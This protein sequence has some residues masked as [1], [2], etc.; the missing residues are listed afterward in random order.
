MKTKFIAGGV[1]L[2]AALAMSTQAAIIDNGTW[3]GTPTT[4][5]VSLD[6][7]GIPALPASI[8]VQGGPNWSVVLFASST[9]P[10]DSFNFAGTHVIAPHPGDGEVGGSVVGLVQSM[11]RPYNTAFGGQTTHL[12]GTH[13]DVWTINVTSQN[14]SGAL[15]T[16]AAVHTPEP[17]QYALF[18]GLGL[19]AFGAFRRFRKA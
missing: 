16:V 19:V 2:V 1:G 6:W 4:L 11:N 14:P 8:Y 3:V 9:G 12:N 18:A 5:S 7:D 13:M 17:H 15:L 10:T